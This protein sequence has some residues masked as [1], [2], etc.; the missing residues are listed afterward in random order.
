MTVQEAGKRGGKAR[1]AKYSP[2]E[3]SAWGTLGGWPKGRSRKPATEKR[4]KDRVG[5]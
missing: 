3:L 5:A 2:E 4:K 1:A